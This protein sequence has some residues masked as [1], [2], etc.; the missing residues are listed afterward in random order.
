MTKPKLRFPEFSEDWKKQKV[1]DLMTRVVNPVKVESETLYEQI[2]IRSHGKGI[3]HKEKVS[4]NQ[5]GNKRIFWLQKDLFVLNIVFAWE[6]AV[7]IT[8]EKEEGLVAS[9]RF[10]MYQSQKD[11]S[12]LK[13]LLFF[14]LTKKGKFYLEL[15]SPGGAGRNK[16]LG[17][18]EFEK[19]KF[20]IPNYSEQKKIADFLTIV[21]DKIQKLTQK[22]EAL[23]RYKKGL[24]QKLFPKAGEMVPELRFPG[25]SGPW[26]EIKLD[27]VASGILSGVT[28]DQNSDIT[29]FPVTR[30]ETISSGKIDFQKVGYVSKQ[31]ALSDFK[32]QKGDLL[33]SNIN[34][35]AHIGKI[36][37]YDSDDELYHGMNLIR[38]VPNPI[39]ITSKFL[40]YILTSIPLK[41]YFERICNKA[42]SQASIN[43]TELAK[44]KI[45]ICD[46]NEQHKIADFLTEVDDKI[47][48]V[49]QQ[50]EKMTQFKKGLLQQMFV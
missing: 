4:G 49:D 8:S 22:K 39:K 36:A 41:R 44:T 30:I 16:T 21:D 27:T 40:Y 46:Q 12:Y 28:L 45:I 17:Q 19:T 37:V 6:Q 13:Y 20:L 31:A 42:V 43:K 15:A 7:A 50:I 25:F 5:I 38:I 3:F 23:S 26:F 11:V 34:S 10:P 47:N 48:K 33:F 24:L 2:G 1:F 35:V 32:L 9:H 18:K 29:G 14:F